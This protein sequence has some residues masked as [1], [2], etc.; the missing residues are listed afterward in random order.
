[1]SQRERHL[2]LLVDV[3][4]GVCAFPLDEL[5]ETMRPLPIEP[6]PDVPGFIRGLAIVRGTPVPVVELAALLGEGQGTPSRRWV[7]V[8]SGART[9]ALAVPRVIGMAEISKEQLA[10]MPPL[11]RS[12]RAELIEAVG[13]L[14][15][16][17]MM[18]LCTARLVP[19]EV[20]RMIER[21]E[22]A[23]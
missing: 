20:W 8:R 4:G 10:G 23:Q 21:G 3:P 14:D 11:L 5:V 1:M 12:G 15:Q 17:L 2:A 19:D 13:T 22:A 7:T 9:I 6:L 18:T 16:Q